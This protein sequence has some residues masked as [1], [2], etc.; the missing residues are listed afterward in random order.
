MRYNRYF[1]FGQS[2][3]MYLLEKRKKSPQQ[4]CLGETV[5]LE[6]A[7]GNGRHEDSPRNKV[8]LH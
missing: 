5:N 8:L 2:E 7:K 1:H 4:C 6:F 3:I